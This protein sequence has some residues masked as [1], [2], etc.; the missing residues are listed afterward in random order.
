MPLNHFFPSLR[1]QEVS[2]RHLHLRLTFHSLLA[3]PFPTR[4]IAGTQSIGVLWL[5]RLLSLSGRIPSRGSTWNTGKKRFRL[6]A[7]SALTT[8]NC[9]LPWRPQ[10]N[11][12][13][14]A[15]TKSRNVPVLCVHLAVCWG[16]RPCGGS[17]WI[18]P[19]VKWKDLLRKLKE[20]LS[21]R[22]FW[23]KFEPTSEEKKADPAGL[24]AVLAW[25]LKPC[26][27]QLL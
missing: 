5:Y 18:L 8:V 2:K 7:C 4:P 3:P 27:I 17:Y 1:V 20:I 13:G 10:K 16:R 24:G 9:F 23:T 22:L 25:S 12:A 11:V 26:Q 21:C 19:G 14:T 15:R 6:R